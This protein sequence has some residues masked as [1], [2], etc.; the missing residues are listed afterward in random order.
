MLTN[1]MHVGKRFKSSKKHQLS[2]LCLI[3]FMISVDTKR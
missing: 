2:G 3:Y 1:A